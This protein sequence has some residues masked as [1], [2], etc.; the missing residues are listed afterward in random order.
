MMAGADSSPRPLHGWRVGFAGLGLMG[1]PMARQLLSAGADLCVWNRTRGVAD[2]FEGPRAQICESPADLAGRSDIVVLMLADTPVVEQV[3][4]GPNGL[5]QGLRAG[6]MVI[7][8]GTT[9]VMPTRGFARRLAQDGI[10]FIDAPVSG[11]EIGA[12]DATLT[13]MAGGDDAAVDR[14]GPLFTVLGRTFTHVG[15][16]GAGQVAKAAN[17]IIV[18]LNIGAVAEALA[19]VKAAGVDQAKVRQALLGGFAGSRILE[20]HGQRMID[21]TFEPG[22]RI[23]TQFKD[24]RQACELGHLLNQ[25]LP[26]TELSKTLFETLIERG[27]GD[28]DHSA[29]IRVLS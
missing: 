29:L 26:A 17:Q 14:A 2:S 9:A 7:D 10:D 3:L 15:A 4:F 5:S 20:V 28:L 13:I 12:I 16:V 11:G 18:G 1:R 25:P 27:D 19:L 21:E 6:S 24:M 22:A 8:M 23:T